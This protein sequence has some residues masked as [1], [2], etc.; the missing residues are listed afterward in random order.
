VRAAAEGGGCFPTGRH[1]PGIAHLMRVSAAGIAEEFDAA[2]AIRDLLLVAIDTET[3]GRD[4][5][6]DRIVEVACVTWANEGVVS[7]RHWLVNPGRSIPK[8]A[9]DVHG[10]TDP[11][12]QGA[13][14][15]AGI[16]D[17]LL[18]ELH[19][20]VPVA[21]NAAFDRAFLNDE[22][23]RSGSRPEATP[24]ALRRGVEWIDPLV[25][26][27]ELQKDEKSKALGEVAGRL[28]IDLVRAH[29]ATDDAEAAVRVLSAFLGD[30]RV[31]VAYGAFIQEQRRLSRLHAEER[32]HWRSAAAAVP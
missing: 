11:D 30:T 14:P 16:L 1:Y 18:E 13:P 32:A 8:E 17:E 10:I 29:R 31:P 2:V 23:S 27:R 15:F 25:W 5:A 6:V 7:R 4:P 3:T 21:Y 24:P 20:K 28:G 9:S 26:A 19:G 12:V 22:L